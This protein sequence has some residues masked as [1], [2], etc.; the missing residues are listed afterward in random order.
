MS[1][2]GEILALVGRQGAQVEECLRLL[3]KIARHQNIPTGD[4]PRTF[5]VQAKPTESSTTDS[6]GGKWKL[7]SKVT[8]N[9]HQGAKPQGK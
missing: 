6:I 1:D 5:H 3:H 4:T 9:Q 7:D 8:P 2:T